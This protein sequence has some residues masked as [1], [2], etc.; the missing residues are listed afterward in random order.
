[1][2]IKICGLRRAIDIEYVN[3][4]KPDYI[5][6]VFADS[7]RKVNIN[8]ATLL[9]ANLDKNIKAV[10]VFRNNDIELIRKAV[11]NNIIDLIQ[12]H[13][14][15]DDSYIL[16]IK[17]FT[18]LPI[19]KAYRDS[20]YSDYSLF[21]NDDPGKGIV[22][23][24]NSINTKKPFFLAG[25]ININNIDDALKINPYCIDVSS[26]VEENGFKDFDKMKEIIKRCRDYE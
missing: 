12:L 5:G 18:N 22:F 9:K 17:E 11:E 26:G 25:G 15:E 4:L 2:L 1:M 19:I 20:K 21:D 6:F 10:G 13:G 16:K 3:K 14:D 8:E 7:K 23:D 24:W